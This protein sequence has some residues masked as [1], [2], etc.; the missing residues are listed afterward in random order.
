[1][2]LLRLFAIIVLFTGFSQASLAQNAA[3][4]PL[5]IIRFN[6]DVVSY[7][8][9]LDKAVNAALDVK[10]TAFFE[11]VAV[12]P[13][14]GDRKNDRNLKEQS[15]YYS[16]Q[17]KENISSKGVAAEKIRLSQQSS[18]VI[19]DNEVHIFVR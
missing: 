8:K 13:Q 9:S 3:E 6:Q 7:E 19:K 12:I 1:M 11:V 18:K 4:K 10:P 5:M 17:I 15:E 2:K 14:T 16:S